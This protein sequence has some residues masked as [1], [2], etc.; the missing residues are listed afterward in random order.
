MDQLNAFMLN[1]SILFFPYMS[2]YIH[3]ST[4]HISFDFIVKY[5]PV[6]S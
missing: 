6:S 1:K 5:G 4:L 3:T 2:M